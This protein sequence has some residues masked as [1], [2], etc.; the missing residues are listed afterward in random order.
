MLQVFKLSC[1]AIVCSR[2]LFSTFCMT[3][4]LLLTQSTV[5][6]ARPQEHSEY[7]FQLSVRLCG[8]LSRN[9]RRAAADRGWA[10]TRLPPSLSVRPLAIYSLIHMEGASHCPSLCRSSPRAGPA[11]KLSWHHRIS[12]YG[13]HTENKITPR[14]KVA[15][16]IAHECVRCGKGEKEVG[17]RACEW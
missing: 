12:T 13:T 1:Q 2:V 6:Y 4:R 11:A 9:W 16:P 3:A 10:R 17:R 7:F 15:T 5:A 14:H 8:R